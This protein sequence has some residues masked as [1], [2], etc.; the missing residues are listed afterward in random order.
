MRF[1]L[2][3]WVLPAVLALAVRIAGAANLH[4]WHDE[5]F[6]VW[7]SQLPWQELVSALRWDSGPPLFYVCV[8]FVSLLGLPPLVAGR[9]FSVLAGVFATVL[10]GLS[11]KKWVSAAAGVWASLLFAVHP[12]AVMWC[13]E[14]R[15]YGLLSLTVAASLWALGQ[16]QAG[17]T[18]WVRLAVALGLGLYTHALGLVWLVAVLGYGLLTG[19]RPVLWA[20]GAAV[21]SFLPWLPV[22]LQQPAEAVAWM[23]SSLRDVP[24]WAVGL[25]PLR[26]LPPLAG[27]W[28]TLEA[29]HVGWPW[30]L[31]GAVALLFALSL[32]RG[33]LWLL[34]ALPAGMLALGWWAGLP[35]YYPGRGEAVLLAPFLVFVASG[36]RNWGRWL[37]VGLVALGFGGSVALVAHYQKTPPRPE[38]HMAQ[39]LLHQNSSGVVVTTGW[40]WLAMR[41]HL[42]ASW[43]VLHL[44]AA[45]LRHPGWFVPGREKV[46]DE[47]K[48]EVWQKLVGALGQGGG[49]GL[50]VTPGLPEAEDLR[51][52]GMRLGWR[53][54]RFSGGE[55]WTPVKER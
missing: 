3:W 54:L 41:S 22:M 7:V 49:A 1:H 4:S 26:L 10:V 43:A 12:L 55:L 24:A 38:E 14:A 13:A 37:G 9:A 40:W 31:A 28:Y 45:A 29:P 33:G 17:K 44:P 46:T 15:A 11:A 20:S 51:S 53:V 27:W 52:W 47:E 34:W 18:S 2:P 30:Q 8:K 25:G 35:V 6:T 42:P 48:T 23:A 36:L 5:Y 16:V 50:V 32:A 19:K 21:G 39:V